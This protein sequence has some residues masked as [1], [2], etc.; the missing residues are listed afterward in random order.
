MRKFITFNCLVDCNDTEPFPSDA[1]QNLRQAVLAPIVYTPKIQQALQRINFQYHRTCSY[2]NLLRECNVGEGETLLMFWGY[3]RS[4]SK[5]TMSMSAS[6]CSSLHLQPS[7]PNSQREKELRSTAQQTDISCRYSPGISSPANPSD[8]EDQRQMRARIADSLT[9]SSPAS[10]LLQPAGRS[11]SIL[12]SVC[13]LLLNKQGSQAAKEVSSFTGSLR[14]DNICRICFGGESAERLVRPCSC[15]G[16]IAAV[17]RSCLERWLLQAAT[18]YCELCR[19]HYVVTRSHKWSWMRSL[20]EWAMSGRGRA[21]AA[22]VWRAL[23]LGTASV[24]GTARALHACDAVLQA[25]AR[26]GGGAALAANLFSSLLIGVI[27][28]LNGLLTTWMLLKIQ[29]HQ[30]SW[31][32]W[33]DSTLHVHVTLADEESTLTPH[34]SDATVVGDEDGNATADRS[35]NVADPFMVALPYNL[36]DT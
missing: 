26:R 32:A 29:E 21:L 24:L 34:P 6:S 2:S 7:T 3:G 19:H 1:I 22:D 27:G 4:D 35:T 9:F 23:A 16:T 11:M 15:R 17:H 13:A 25:G 12:S 28:A 30:L 18:S 20:A 31:Q 5:V 36:P 14:S 33:R 8:T 10:S